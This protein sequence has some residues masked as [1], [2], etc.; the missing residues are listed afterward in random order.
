[1]KHMT[2]SEYEILR[3]K[4]NGTKNLLQYLQILHSNMAK[5]T[6]FIAVS[7][8]GAAP[9]FT[10][11]HATAMMNLGLKINMLRRYRQPYLA[12]ISNGIVLRELV[13]EQLGTPLSFTG[14]IEG[15]EIFMYSGGFHCTVSY[16]RKALTFI[17]DI[18]YMRSGRGFCFLVYDFESNKPI[19]SRTYDTFDNCKLNLSSNAFGR[20]LL[21][22]IKKWGGTVMHNYA[23]R[24]TAGKYA[25]S[26]RMGEND[27]LVSQ[28]KSR[29]VA[30]YCYS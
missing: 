20:S 11:Q 18:S 3:T 6:V 28:I 8:T 21:K 14:N 25:K 23:S 24:I 15:H 1:M 9:H 7:D 30:Q 26:F 29:L 10:E 27:L 17:D 22:I 5:I 2:N 19:D 16:G 4:I 12:I 13:S